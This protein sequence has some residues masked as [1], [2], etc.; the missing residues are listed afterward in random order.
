MEAMTLLKHLTTIVS[1]IFAWIAKG[2]QKAP[3]TG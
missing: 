3:C 2:Q 1:R